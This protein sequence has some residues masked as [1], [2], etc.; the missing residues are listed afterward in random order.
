MGI[1]L[2]ATCNS[3]PVSD[4]A[5]FSQ[6]LDSLNRLCLTS[7]YIKHQLLNLIKARNV[8]PSHSSR[9][10]IINRQPKQRGFT[11]IE[12]A[13]VLAIAGLIFLVVF[14][15]LPALQNSQKDTARRQDVARVIS[16]LQAYE[17]DGGNLADLASYSAS[18]S[19]SSVNGT[20]F[21]GYVGKLSQ[22]SS[23]TI[24]GLRR[25]LNT[26]DMSDMI[27]NIREYPD[28]INS[29]LQVSIG[30]ACVAGSSGYGTS[31]STDAAIYAVLS[32]G[33][34]YCASM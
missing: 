25:K 3:K 1:F 8:T 2:L 34:V 31:T 19:T 15:A 20:G 27:Q 6:T 21:S 24:Y 23:I 18:Y 28:W 32:N 4:P 30:E 12:V 14:L 9:S 13:L 33:T 29:E 26:S 17:A 22:Y 10:G 16:A 7:S 11:I 5:L